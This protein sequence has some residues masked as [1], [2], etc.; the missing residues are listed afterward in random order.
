[1]EAV[2]AKHEVEIKNIKESLS[3]IKVEVRQAVNAMHKSASS[4]EN[5]T[6]MLT[7]YIK[8]SDFRATKQGERIRGL[9]NKGSKKW[10][11]LGAA[12]IGAL[13]MGIVAYMLFQLGLSYYSYSP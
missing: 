2:I 11:S 10:E 6:N 3:E 7:E 13:V 1:M 4:Q 8:S 5:L 12:I 9:E